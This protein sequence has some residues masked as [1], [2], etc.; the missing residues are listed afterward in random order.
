MRSDSPGVR[1]V[2]TFKDIPKES[3]SLPVAQM[4]DGTTIP[5]PLL[6]HDEVCYVGEPIAFIVADNR[7]QAEDAIELVNVDYVPLPAVSES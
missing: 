6:A 1:Q 7:Y 5:W 3:S 4:K 2:I